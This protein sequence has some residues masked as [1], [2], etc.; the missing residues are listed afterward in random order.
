MKERLMNE[1]LVFFSAIFCV[2]LLYPVLSIFNRSSLIWGI[3][4]LYLYLFVAWIFIIAVLFYM[5][6]KDNR[7]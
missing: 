2:L 5:V 3:P 1:K 6:R 4:I 7:E